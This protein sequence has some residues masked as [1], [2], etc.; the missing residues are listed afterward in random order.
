MTYLFRTSDG[1][2]ESILSETFENGVFHC[3][4]PTELE[5]T[6]VQSEQTIQKFDTF[7]VYTRR[8]SCCIV[9][10]LVKVH[11]L[12]SLMKFN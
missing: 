9:C 4:A 2:L 1:A 6:V 12:Y 11:D 10:G 7:G 3:S 8:S 5:D